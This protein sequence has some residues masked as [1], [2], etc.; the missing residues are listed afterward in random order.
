M[1]LLAPAA[2]EGR[3]RGVGE[4]TKEQTTLQPLGL[5]KKETKLN[6]ASG[7]FNVKFSPFYGQQWPLKHSSSFRPFVLAVT[8]SLKPLTVATEGLCCVPRTHPP[9]CANACAHRLG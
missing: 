7:T 1:T 4:R 5:F 9:R 2:A 8:F 3:C 6:T